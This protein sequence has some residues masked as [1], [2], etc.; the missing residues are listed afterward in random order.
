M[1][2][3]TDLKQIAEVVKGVVKEEVSEQLKPIEKRLDAIEEQLDAIE[4]RLDN[5]EY[6]SE[7]TRTASN[8]LVKWVEINFSHKYPFL[9]EDLSA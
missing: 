3:P 6:N 7:I 4:E 1:L 5:L 2:S 8:E 9:V